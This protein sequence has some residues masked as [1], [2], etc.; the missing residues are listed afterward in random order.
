MRGEDMSVECRMRSAECRSGSRGRSTHR[1]AKF[2]PGVLPDGHHALKSI[3]RGRKA[4]RHKGSLGEETL[5]CK[6]VARDCNGFLKG[7]GWLPT[8]FLEGGN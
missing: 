3:L 5:N 2:G 7:M 8:A 1:G 4:N 6:S